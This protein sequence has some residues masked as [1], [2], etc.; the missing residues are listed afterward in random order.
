M[1]SLCFHAV[2][3]SERITVMGSTTVMP[4]IAEAAKPFRAS[5]PQLT[6][7]V[8]GG[9]S[10]VGIA[11]VRKGT[12]TIGMASRN[13]SAWE[14]AEM[15]QEFKVYAIGRD[16]VAAAV[17]QAIFLGG[18]QHLTL[19]EIA[20]I[21]RGQISN[22]RALGG[23]DAR[24]LVIDKEPSRGTRH[25]FAKAV[26]GNAHA[27]APGATIISGSNNE[28]QATI[29]R[30]DQAIGQLSLAWMNDRVRALAIEIDGKIIA[31]TIPHIADGSYPIQRSLNIIVHRDAS[32]A[33]MAFIN[34][35]LSKDGQKIV[36]DVGYLP[37]NP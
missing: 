7:T 32:P 3:A 28:E 23:P 15:G 25:V 12:A 17:S 1:L 18:V 14:M 33:V 22:W 37:V 21:Y 34:F 4:I 8:S 24:I 31:P 26:F 29:A 30:S 2:I 16:A 11:S 5:H 9:G 13:L 6:I 36:R 19:A 27:R 35:L 20:S 10:G